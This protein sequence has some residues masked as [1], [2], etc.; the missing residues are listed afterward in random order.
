M[1]NY[2]YYFE[3]FTGEF[4]SYFYRQVKA[5]DMKNAIIQIV[6]YFIN[7]STED[8]EKYIIDRLKNTLDFI[9][10]ETDKNNLEK[11]NWTEEM[12]WEKIDTRFMN[13]NE[14]VGYSLIWIKEISFDLELV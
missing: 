14:Y 7:I 5:A 9:D 1:K 12:F 13:E 10:V 11:V 2:L 8:A 6:A 4:E 3:F